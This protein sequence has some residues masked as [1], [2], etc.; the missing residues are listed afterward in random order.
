MPKKVLIQAYD[1]IPHNS[2]S[3][4]G[5]IGR[6]NIELLSA[7]S[8]LSDKDI[9]I[10]IYCDG[11]N[12]IGFS[13]YGWN[14]GYHSFPFPNHISNYRSSFESWYRRYIIGY[15]LFHYTN[16]VGNMRWDSKFVV[17]MHDMYRYNSSPWDKL[18]FHECAD[19]SCGI[20]TC[21]NFSKEDIV[22]LLKVEPSKVTVI[23]WG[24]SHSLFH[25]YPE[26]NVEN[27]LRK[28]H[29]KDKYFFACSC[30]NPR[31]NGDVIAEAA[32][33]LDDKTIS[34]VLAWSNPPKRILDQYQKEIDTR[35]LVFLNYLSDEELAILYSGALASI[36]VSSFEGFGF[37]ILESMACGTPC[38]TCMNTS[39][40][41]IGANL[42]LYVKEKDSY[43]LA[44]AIRS[45]VNG[46]NVNYNEM[47]NYSRG[48]SW[49]NTATEYIKFYKKYL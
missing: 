44:D 29:I 43:D 22:D 8:R 33:L 13:H 11:K 49:E 5:G 48:F 14:F 26:S 40:T 12:S 31:K 2:S 7:L 30:S 39:L 32:H 36:F 4:I 35:Q 28:Y 34:V 6:S 17:T 37:P 1:I 23:P 9:D 20:V 24:I 45:F 42:A 19:K 15:D 18:H 3:Y 27:L 25:P 21:S 16:N 38:I 47:I 46:E 41:E 10:H